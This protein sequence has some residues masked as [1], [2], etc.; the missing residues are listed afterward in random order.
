[1]TT[2][3]PSHEGPSA[4]AIPARELFAT[5]ALIRAFE[6]SVAELYKRRRHPRLRPHLA[7]P[8]GGG[9]RGVHRAR[10]G[11]LPGDHAPRPR[12]LPGKGRRRRRHDGRAVRAR[13]GDLRRQGRLDARGRPV[14]RRARRERDRRREPPARRR[15]RPVEQAARPGTGRG[16]VLRR[17]RGQPG[18]LPRVGQPGGDLG[19]AGA[20]R[21]REQH[22]RRV[23]G[24]PPDDAR[25][26]RR[27]AQRRLRRSRG[28]PSTGTTSR[29]ST[30]RRATRPSA[31]AP[32]KARS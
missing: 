2:K 7:R 18:R 21:L 1:M 12:A 9:R 19:P 8:G 25:A 22:L 15:R 26:E 14:P 27:R 3:S 29:P 11:R 5:M 30:P 16:R 23:L 6:T 32:A 13:R 4:A 20:A 17:G 10:A 28:A 31:A 24:Q